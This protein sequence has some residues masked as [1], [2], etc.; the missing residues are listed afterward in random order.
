MQIHF[1][2]CKIE[3]YLGGL[4][5][6]QFTKLHRR[7][8]AR[9]S[10]LPMHSCT[11][12]NLSNHCTVT[13]Q[14]FLIRSYM[15]TADNSRF[16]KLR[17]YNRTA[18]DNLS[19]N[20]KMYICSMYSWIL[21][22][23]CSCVQQVFYWTACILSPVHPIYLSLIELLQWFPFKFKCRG[24]QPAVRGPLLQAQVNL[25][26]SKSSLEKN[27]KQGCLLSMRSNVREMS[28]PKHR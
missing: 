12:E 25:T 16:S 27:V 22:Y 18:A 20:C 17:L 5:L 19:Y 26:Q 15:C 6:E 8:T 10:K 2:Y 28:S 11:V 4:E 24:N 3:I 23:R 13:E 9:N 21:S 1:T 14:V 7:T